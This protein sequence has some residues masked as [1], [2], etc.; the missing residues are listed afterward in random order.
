[1][2]S[3]EIKVGQAFPET[4]TGEISFEEDKTLIYGQEVVQV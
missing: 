1:M 4:V 2:Y 3:L